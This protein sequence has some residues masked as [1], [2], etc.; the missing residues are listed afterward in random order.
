ME[1]RTWTE[2]GVARLAVRL[3]RVVLDPGEALPPPPP[4][5]QQVATPKTVRDAYAFASTAGGGFFNSVHRPIAVL[6]VTVAP[7]A[8]G[9]ATPPA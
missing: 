9:P 3:D 8:V 4:D 1:I 6:V 7:V 5:S 2:A